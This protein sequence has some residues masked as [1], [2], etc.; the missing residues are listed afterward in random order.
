LV[1]ADPALEAKDGYWKYCFRSGKETITAAR[2][3]AQQWLSGMQ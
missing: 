1:F 3:Y 2:Q